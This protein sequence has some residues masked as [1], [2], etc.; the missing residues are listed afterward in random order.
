M[1]LFLS[2]V[3]DWDPSPDLPDPSGPD[4]L[5]LGVGAGFCLGILLFAIGYGLLGEVGVMLISLA[6]VGATLWQ[7]ARIILR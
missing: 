1:N 5:L 2:H 3:E 4:I 7:C 6:G